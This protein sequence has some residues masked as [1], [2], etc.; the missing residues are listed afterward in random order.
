[1]VTTGITHSSMW[2]VG[3]FNGFGTSITVLMDSSGL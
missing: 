1:M 2:H 3:L